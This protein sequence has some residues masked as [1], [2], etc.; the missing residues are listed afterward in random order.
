MSPLGVDSWSG[1]K[2]RAAFPALSLFTAILW[3][4]LLF[5]PLFPE[6]SRERTVLGNEAFLAGPPSAL[7]GKKLGL[8]VNR[9]SV[10][11]DGI[12]LHRKLLEQGYLLPLLFTPEHGYSGEIEAGKEVHDSRLEAIPVVSLYGRTKKPLPEHVQKIDAFL[13]DIQ[14]VGTRYY[15]Y[16]TTLKYILEA[17]AESGKSVYVL[18]RPVPSGGVI[19]EGPILRK[20]FSSFIGALPIPVRYGMTP[21][22]LAL[23]MKGEGWVPPDVDLHVVRMENWNRR[24]FWKDT[25]LPWIPTSPNIPRPDT[26]LIYPGTGLLGGLTI[27]QGLGTPNPFLQFGAPWMDPERII[28]R[29][30]GGRRF[31]IVLE[32]VE[33]TPV[34][35]PGKVLRPPYENRLCRGVRIHISRREIFRSVHFVLE[36]IR[37]LKEIHPASIRLHEENLNRLFGCDLL[38]GYVRGDVSYSELMENVEKDEKRFM[39]QRKPYLLYGPWEPPKAGP[40]AP[41]ASTLS[42]SSSREDRGR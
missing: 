15:T 19:V 11:P 26:A 20:E 34:S 6:E 32:P 22:E 30:G 23:M 28:R 21:G 37:T 14:D 3:G 31:G 25:G 41:P 39:E 27:N 1:R 17:A 2:A 42:R 13:F 24:Y 35:I 12:P 10:L 29:L 5:S 38:A 36:L 4:M 18:D 16:I 9:T 40:P 8:V 33:Y 7:R